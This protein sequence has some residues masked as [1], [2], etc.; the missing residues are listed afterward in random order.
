MHLKLPYEAT[1]LRL[2]NPM[3]I[4][5]V[6]IFWCT[7]CA[8]ESPAAATD[9]RNPL[10]APPASIEHGPQR[11]T[12]PHLDRQ[13]ENVLQNPE[14]DWRQPALDRSRPDPTL[15]SWIA[16][17]RQALFSLGRWMDD[18]MKWLIDLIGNHRAVPQNATYGVPFATALLNVLA[19]ILFAAAAGTAI[20]F[21]IRVL[22]TKRPRLPVPVVVSEN[23]H[24]E[25]EGIAAN[26]LPDDEWY[27]LAREKI[28]AGD[29]R[30]AQRA[31]FLAIL[32]CLASRRFITIERWKS[33]C[34]YENE[35]GRRAK[36]LPELPQLYVESRLGFE[37]CWYG[38]G[39]LTPQELETYGVIYERIR[40][41]AA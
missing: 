39:T 24:L 34:D 10:P 20:L 15:K 33:N 29:L 22:K 18:A 23:P 12:R 38:T 9:A 1:S 14:F 8:A 32:S 5:T 7:V 27:K 4:V 25:D 35:L 11:L 2:F 17:I 16:S 21:A 6:A 40:D 19:Y 30:Q 31:I 41:V 36:D 28:A 26:E 13:I 37:R 3:L